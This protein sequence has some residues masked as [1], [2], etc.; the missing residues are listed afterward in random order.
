VVE[1]LRIP[2]TVG[3][4]RER[5]R[6]IFGAL[7]Q[8]C[9]ANPRAMPIIER[10][11]FLPAIFRPMEASLAALQDASIGPQDGM[12]AYFLLTNFTLGQVSTR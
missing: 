6:A 3:D 11:E 12:R 9:L 4:W 8:V 1:E 2:P 10:A 7:R 5:L